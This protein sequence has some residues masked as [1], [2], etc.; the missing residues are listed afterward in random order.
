MRSI[1]FIGTDGVKIWNMRTWEMIP[2]PTAAGL[3]G[4]T[5]AL[6]WIR[7]EDELEIGLIYGTQAGFL[8]GWKQARDIENGVSG[9][10]NLKPCDPVYSY[11]QRR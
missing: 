8:V 4:A 11:A 2:C 7:R 3:R 1:N 10:Y 9:D 5:T 6:T